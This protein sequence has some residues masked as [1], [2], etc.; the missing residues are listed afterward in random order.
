MPK[1]ADPATHTKLGRGGLADIEWT[2]QLLQMRYAG[3]L[4]SL[5]TPRTL[6]AVAAAREAG[7]LAE[8]DADILTE[9]WR[10]VSRVRNAVT[11]ARGRS[12]DQLP[13][14]VRERMA[15]ARI[16]DYP[17]GRTEELVNDYLR[18]TR[19]A[20]GVVERVF[21]GPDA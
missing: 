1:G 2:I 18:V 3:E 21:W 19:L 12:A 20:R 14:D 6:T 13:D 11:L 9:A 10:M 16:L 17:V 15:V 8:H 5:R 4:P 7:L